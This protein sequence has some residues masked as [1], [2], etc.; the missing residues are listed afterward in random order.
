MKNEQQINSLREN[1]NKLVSK[2]LITGNSKRVQWEYK[3]RFTSI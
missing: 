1:Y 2:R 3:R